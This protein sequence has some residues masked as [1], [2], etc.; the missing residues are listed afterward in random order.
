[1]KLDT[2]SGVLQAGSSSYF[3]DNVKKVEGLLLDSNK[4]RS[5]SESDTEY[6]LAVYDST[7]HPLKINV[8]GGMNIIFTSIDGARINCQDWSKVNGDEEDLSA[9]TLVNIHGG[10]YVFNDGSSLNSNLKYVMKKEYILALMSQ[11]NTLARLNK[12]FE[13]KISY[14]PIDD[15]DNPIIIKVSDRSSTISGNDY[16]T[17]KD[18]NDN[19]IA[20]GGGGFK[21]MR[22]RTYK[23]QAN[24]INFGMGFKVFMN[25]AFINNNDNDTNGIW[26][27]R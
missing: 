24:G 7:G 21:L 1:M 9:N 10:K 4:V 6:I 14:G 8:Y 2:V 5:T 13:G 23:F 12:G 20:I 27:I 3:N 22:G 16:F 25:G 15:T 19:N 17:F 18:A 26:F 11:K